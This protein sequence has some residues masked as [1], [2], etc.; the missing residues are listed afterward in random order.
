MPIKTFPIGPIETN[1]YIV[2]NETDA[3]IVDTGADAR[4]GLVDVRNFIDGKN[5]NL[6]AIFLTHMHFDH[7]LGVADLLESYPNAKVY[8]SKG[9]DFILQPSF[10]SRS[11][12]GMPTV[13]RF[14]YEDLKAGAYSAGSLECEVRL[15]PGHSPGGAV[16]Y[17]A[18]EKSAFTGDSLFYRS[19]G[20]TDLPG[21]DYNQLVESLRTQIYTLPEDTVVYPGHGPASTV[22][23]EKRLNPYIKYQ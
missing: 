21:S 4:G 3:V 13:K 7:V 8:A 11:S 1:T 12:W 20:R 2:Y 23:D 19:V 17:F 22:G 10:D 18:A 9:D 14:K 16:I 6:Q 5:L 15:S